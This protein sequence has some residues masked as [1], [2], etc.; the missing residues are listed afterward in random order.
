MNKDKLQFDILYESKRKSTWIALLLWLLL[1]GVGAQHFY[2]QGS[3]STIGWLCVVFLLMS[4]F[5][6][7]FYFGVVLFWIIGLFCIRRDLRIRNMEVRMDL[8]KKYGE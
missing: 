8:E 3:N 2:I 5:I 7:V 4:V 6:P 1:G